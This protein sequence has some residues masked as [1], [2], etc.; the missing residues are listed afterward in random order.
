MPESLWIPATLI[1]AALQ[2]ARN[3]AQRGLT[4]S[5]GVAGSAW[6][7]FLYGLPFAVL[8]LGSELVIRGE[9]LPPIG[10]YA[11]LYAAFGG[12][13]QILA[14][15][16]LLA[17]ME[18]RAFSVATAMSKTEPVMVAALG[19]VFLNERLSALQICAVLIATGGLLIMSPRADRRS[20]SGLLLGASSGLGF[21]LASIAY[22]AGIMMI[23]S[24]NAPLRAIVFLVLTL[25][26]QCAMILIWLIAFDR[27]LLARLA[28]TWRPSLAAGFFGAAASAFWFLGFA[29]TKAANVR[30]LAL[31][32][33][34]L[35][36]LVS[37]RIFR[38]QVR[39][40]EYAGM[41]LILAGTGLLIL[42]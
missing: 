21:A 14:T 31:I 13:G 7:R 11:A 22:R 35:A 4:E 15:M 9:A 40:G 8:I 6:I 1:A 16:L 39:A 37:Q 18:R 33:V 24:D 27:P 26:L 3:A 34:P 20:L 25:S 10:A 41:T 29:L 5:L 17:A 19:F 30:T 12:A 23:K 28:A 36:Q 42:L 38:Q 32:E 2:T